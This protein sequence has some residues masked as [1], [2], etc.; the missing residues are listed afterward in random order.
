MV[1]NYTY[2]QLLAQ[3]VDSARS[4][5]ITNVITAR[6]F[7]NRGARAVVSE[8]DLRSTKRNTVLG[9]DLFDEVYSYPCPTD[10][11]DTGIIDFQPQVNRSRDFRLELVSEQEF[12]MKKTVKNNII[13]L[14]TDELAKKLLF[15]GDVTDTVLSAATMDSLTAD[16]G[17]WALFGDAENVV[18]DAD[19]YI[20]GSGSVKFDISAAGGTTAGLQNTSVTSMDIS[21]YVN[22]GHVFVWVYVNSTTNLTNWILRI[23]NDSSNYYT[24]TVTTTHESLSFVAGWN[25]LRFDFASMTET[26][27]VTDTAIDYI[28]IYMT[29][30]AAK[31]DDGYRVD[32][33]KLHTGQIHNV[34]Y[35]SRY[36]WQ[37]TGAVFLENST[38][39]TD[40]INAETDEIDG[41]VHRCKAELYKELRR[42][43]LVKLAMEDYNAWKSNYKK[44]NPSERVDMNRNY[45]EPTRY[46]RAF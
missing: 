6:N 8:V 46:H 22:A 15:S 7:I 36:P 11:K 10:L 2:T 13:A 34:V 39:D 4:S 44:Y 31:A 32:S 23:G 14:A 24:Q 18:A 1:S 42:F 16:G 41:F 21:D 19:N 20:T 26:G 5:N 12:D 45:W 3:V 40:C 17:T 28:A 27:T 25:L 30:A 43:D 38:A 29:K 37:T 35:Y 9:T 33:I